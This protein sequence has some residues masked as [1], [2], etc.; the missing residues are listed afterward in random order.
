MVGLGEASKEIGN[1]LITGEIFVITGPAQSGKASLIYWSLRKDPIT[2]V[3]TVDCSLYR[4]E[5]QFIQR[6]TKDLGE[7]IGACSLDR[8]VI[9]NETI[10]F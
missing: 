8:R 2:V 1:R 10:R 5:M 6:L 9:V 7:K 4:T 3:V